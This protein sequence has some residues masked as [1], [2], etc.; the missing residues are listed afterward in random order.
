MAALDKK[1]N[2]HPNLTR[3][4]PTNIFCTQPQGCVII[5]EYNGFYNDGNHYSNYAI[6]KI[7]EHF[8]LLEI[9]PPI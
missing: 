2:D 5:D 4:K 3:V 7:I 6:S 1:L 8:K 9:K